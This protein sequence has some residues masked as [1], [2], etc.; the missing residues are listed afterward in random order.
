MIVD[1]ALANFCNFSELRRGGDTGR[2]RVEHRSFFQ[3]NSLNI[4]DSDGMTSC[5]T[6]DFQ[7]GRNRWY[8]YL[9]YLNLNEIEMKQKS[10]KYNGVLGLH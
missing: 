1:K 10:S 3:L 7:N 8:S 4:G 6:Y 5:N 9:Y 2:R